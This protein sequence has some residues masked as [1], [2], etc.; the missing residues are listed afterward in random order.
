M[1]NYDA[2]VIV[3]RVLS[4][5]DR[6]C[7]FVAAQ[8]D[9]SA[10]HV[11]FRGSDTQPLPGD[12]FR[13]KGLLATYK[14]RQGRTV[15]QVDCNCMT[16]EVV[17]GHLLAPRLARLPNVGKVRSERL[18]T[19]YGG[20][21]AMTLRDVGRLREVAQVLE[22]AKP[23]LAL[24]IAAQVFAAAAGDAATGKIK[25]A[26]IEFLTRLEALGVRES[27]AANQLWRLLAGEDAYDRLLR[28]PYV[29]AS[30]MDWPLVDRIGKRLLR[31]SG[32]G[33]DLVTH[34]KRL[35]GA[36]SSVYRELLTAGDTAAEPAAIAVLIS[37]RGVDPSLCMQYAESIAALKRSCDLIRVPGA[38][39]LEDRIAVALW[40][41]EHQ[42]HSIDVPTG[43][44]LRRLVVDSELAAGIE[45]KG[46][47]PSA[48]ARLLTLPVGVLQGGAGVGKTTTMRVVAT[49]WEYLGGDVVL[50]ALPGKAALTLS[51]GASS[52][53][54]PRLAY[55]VARLIQ[56]L[57]R[58][59]AQDNNPS[60]FRPDGDVT[61]TPRTLMVLDEAGMLD[62]PSLHRLLHLLPAGVRLLFVGDDGQ[63]PPVGIGQV[64]HDLVQEGSRAVHLTRVLRTKDGSSIP[65]IAAQVRAGERLSLPVWA[66]ETA[67][68]FRLPSAQRRAAQRNLHGA[69]EMLV[70]AAL[71]ATVSAINDE[72]VGALRTS[73]TPVRRLG[74]M[75][76][77]A[78]GDRVIMTVNRYADALF[79]GLLGRV[80]SIAAARVLVHWDGEPEPREL[81][82]VA[83]A[84]IELAY[85]ITC[86]KAQGS[87][88][89]NVLVVVERT[90]IVTRQW[91]YTA[92]TRSRQLVLLLSDDDETIN[93]AVG[94]STIRTTGFTMP[95]RTSIVGHRAT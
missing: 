69:G 77:V 93:Q 78:A 46:D 3:Q 19:R 5:L 71:R 66:G 76:T 15:P 57:E 1:Q 26:E 52:A 72:E 27:R 6:G 91:L 49:A 63:L 14:D 39:W 82:E 83:E 53:S 20:E 50:G 73:A 61:L 25:A 75:A 68:V 24:R 81:P 12:A 34:P 67:G 16:R 94:R 59:K 79:N 36:L 47:Q 43:D 88:A 84:E 32:R 51:R 10:I 23:A 33:A 41:I 87:A 11:R 2:V 31:E 35:M 28:N 74:P 80:I 40:A 9:G 22:P 85:A 54:R 64:F 89:D 48:V 38:A 13:V 44:A 42:T 70:L 37:E 65:G 95:A 62:T 60:Q 55:T 17:H 29:S 45:L 58:Q 90:P 30:L 56:M 7:I 18:V 4:Q 92:I 86:H 21:L 8:D